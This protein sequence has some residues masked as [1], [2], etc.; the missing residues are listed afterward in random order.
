[1]I[2]SLKSYDLL[3]KSKYTH[4]R[5]LLIWVPGLDFF[6]PFGYIQRHSE[7]NPG[8]VIRNHSWQAQVVIWD[9]GDETQSAACKTIAL[10]AVLLF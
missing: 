1:M 2:Y 4:S 3:L 6:P 9:P 5:T 10:L 7:I 8:S